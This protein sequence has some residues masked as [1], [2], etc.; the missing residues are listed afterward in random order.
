MARRR[1]VAG[2]VC[3][4]LDRRFLDPCAFADVR[5][6]V[7]SAGVG[8]HHDLGADIDAIEKVSHIVVNQPDAARRHTLADGIRGVG[9]VD[10]ESE[11]PRYIARAPSGLPGPPAMKRGR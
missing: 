7:A 8:Q 2:H 11:L 10:P 6:R 1:G 4:W 5:D 9:A 3:R